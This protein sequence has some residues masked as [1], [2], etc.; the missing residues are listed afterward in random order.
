MSAQAV[1]TQL[2]NVLKR[3][4]SERQITLLV[5]HLSF[6][7][8][9]NKKLNLTSVCDWE[10]GIVVHVE[11]SLSALPELEGA[12]EGE[13]IDLGS[14]GGFP[15]I[16]LAIVSTRK[17]TLSEATKKKAQ[18]LRLFVEQ[19]DL[20]HQISIEPF[21]AEELARCEHN[22]ERFSVVTARALAPLPALMELAAPLLKPGGILIAYKGNPSDKELETASSISHELG[23]SVTGQRKL[24]LSDG[25]SK[26]TIIQV[27][28]TA[29][30]SYQLPRRNGQSQKRYSQ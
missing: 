13:L 2:E 20:A 10:T 28:K 17:T 4:L 30:S 15:G 7:G 21:R 12:P 8:E 3:P 18:V 5:S 22:L 27:K 14:G 26:R 16:P 19:N 6:V 9:Q 11:D 29:Q 23:M 25:L 1:Q 24:L